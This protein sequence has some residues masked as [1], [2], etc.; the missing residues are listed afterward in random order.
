MEFRI[1]AR[2]RE[3]LQQKHNVS[4]EEVYQAF[5]NREGPSFTDDRE[6]HQSVPPTYWFIAETDCG[7][8]LKIVYV[9][10]PEFFAI[11]SAFDANDTWT[12]LYNDACSKHG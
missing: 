8:K 11:K 5:M 6:D 2:I 3:K 4:V 10:Y 7:R 1:S 9:A 12:A